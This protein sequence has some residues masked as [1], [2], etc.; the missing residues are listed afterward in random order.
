MCRP[1]FPPPDSQSPV[2][3]F[4]F[5]DGAA[6]IGD[7]AKATGGT[8]CLAL[9]FCTLQDEVRRRPLQLRGMDLD[10]DDDDEEEEQEQE[11]QGCGRGHQPRRAFDARDREQ[12]E[13]KKIK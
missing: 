4:S 13:R 8:P 5:P 11:N 6:A 7:C 3:S 10:L 2:P 9:L 12:D 1:S